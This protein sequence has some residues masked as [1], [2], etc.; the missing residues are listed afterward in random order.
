MNSL[1]TA[2]LK[3]LKEEGESCGSSRARDCGK[4]EKGLKCNGPAKK[5][6]KCVKKQGN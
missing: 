3:P 6:G 4:C 1:V 2:I 5:C